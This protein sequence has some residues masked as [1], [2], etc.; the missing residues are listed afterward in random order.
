MTDYITN[1]SATK[2][3]RAVTIAPEISNLHPDVP[4]PVIPRNN[5]C[6]KVGD[7]NVITLETIDYTDQNGVA[8]KWDMAT[9]KGKG[10]DIDVADAVIVVPLLRNSGSQ[11][12]DTLLVEQYRPPV[13][14]DTMEFPAGLI[15]KGESPEDAAMRRIR[16]E[17]GYVGKECS[18]MPGYD[19]SRTLCMSP[20]LTNETV[21]CVLVDVDLDDPANQGGLKQ[22]LKDGEYT[23]VKRVELREG[24]NKVLE[25]GDNMPYA[26]LYMFSLGLETGLGM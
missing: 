5:L 15:K 2:L 20:G 26:G 3:K 6:H 10:S 21:H 12:V 17:T 23:V 13:G 18:I 8:R 14:K 16:E 24:L 19:V 11:K 7:T 1:T 22:D 4:R 9:R 25:E